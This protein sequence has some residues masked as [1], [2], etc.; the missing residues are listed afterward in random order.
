[1][2]DSPEALQ[3]LTEAIGKA[4]RADAAVVRLREEA[5]GDLAARA[6]WATSAVVSAELV[7]SRG[8]LR[9]AGQ[10]GSALTIPIKR[11]NEV[12]GELELLRSG[13]PFAENDVSLAESAAAQAAL[14]L[15]AELGSVGDTEARRE[16]ELALAGEAL[17][18][19]SGGSAGQ[20]VQVAAEAGGASGAVLWRAADGDVLTLAAEVTVDQARIP[21]LEQAAADM[22]ESRASV[23]VEGSVASVR[24]GEPPLGVLQLVFDGG[25]EPVNGSAGPLATFGVRAAQA[26]RANEALVETEAEL[27]RTRALLAVIGQAIA[28]LSLS[29]TLE[30]AVERIA[31][32]L[33]VERVAVYLLDGGRLQPVAGRGLAGPHARV[34]DSLLSLALGPLRGRQALILAPGEAAELLTACAASWPNRESKACWL[35]RW[36]RRSR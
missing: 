29:H 16:R 8:P 11:G 7:G 31:E 14:V 1:M 6:V 33:G 32:L 27:E 5:S 10:D 4:L 22:L 23:A 25:A 15:A 36:S 28:Q 24:L 20:L 19:A 34:G 21:E 13:E 9:G 35:S 26:I 17:A 3:A 18:L 2:R 30:T 12:V